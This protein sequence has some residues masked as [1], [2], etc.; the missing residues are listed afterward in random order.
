MSDITPTLHLLCGKVAA[1]KSTLAAQLAANPVTIKISEDAWLSHLFPGEIHT[2]DDYIRCSGRLREPMGEHIRELLAKG[3]S[4][5]LDF[6]ANT[7]RLRQWM[8][9]LADDVGVRHEL[10]YVDVPDEICKARLR[11]RNKDGTHEFAV[12]ESE[13]DAITAYFMAPT[14]DEKLNVIVHR[15]H[16]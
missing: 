13:F 12:T 8:R 3:V 7:V 9:S 5:V 4:V 16:E 11:Q 14:E 10:H 15:L 2:V 1:G 6:P